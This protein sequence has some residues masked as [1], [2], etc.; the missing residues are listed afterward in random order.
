MPPTAAAAPAVVAYT[1]VYF[2]EEAALPAPSGVYGKS[3]AP[4]KTPIVQ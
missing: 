1:P 2:T 3:I 4:E